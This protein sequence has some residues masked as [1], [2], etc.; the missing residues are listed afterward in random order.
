MVITAYALCAVIAALCAALLLTR[1][2]TSK[3]RMLFWCGLCF[4]VLFTTNMLAAV[5]TASSIELTH[6]RLLTALFAICL[7]LYG[8]IFEDE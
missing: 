1:A 6:S 2:R 7:L 4:A 5:D 8:L 3:S